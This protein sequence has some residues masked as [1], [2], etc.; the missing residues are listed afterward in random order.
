VHLP[1]AH[2]LCICQA[3]DHAQ[4]PFLIAPLDVRLEADEVVERSG[5]VVLAQ[6]H[7]RE[8]PPARPRVAQPHGPHRAE[9][10]RHWVACGHDFDGQT[11]LEVA[12]RLV[13]LLEL[14]QT[15]LICRINRFHEREILVLAQ[16]AVDVIALSLRIGQQH[17]SFA[18]LRPGGFVIAALTKRD[19]HIDRLGAHDGRHRVEEVEI[20]LPGQLADSLC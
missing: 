15:D 11:A 10:Q 4:H 18:R 19:G 7:D 16:R 5:C 14:P 6:L 8:R 1:E 12:L 9:C 2:E 3:G 20:V 13:F 17:S